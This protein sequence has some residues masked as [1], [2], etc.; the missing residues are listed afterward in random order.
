VTII[1]LGPVLAAVL[2]LLTLFAAAVVR[3]GGLGGARPVVT[4]AVRAAVQLA[5]VSL[6]IAAVL[7]S[8]WWTALFVLLMATVAAVTS[9]RRISGYRTVPWT[10]VSIVAGTAPVIVLLLSTRLVPTVPV[11]VVPI[12]GILIGNAMTVTTLAG[13]RALDELHGRRG[14]Y[15]AALALGLLSRDA[16]LEICRPSAGQ[17]LVPTMDQTRTVGLVT[18]PGAFVGMLLGGAGPVQAGAAQLVVLIGLLAA[19]AIA[20]LIIVE[21]IAA[22]AVRAS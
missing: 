8:W 14:E 9:A 19:Q 5:A 13:R 17:A 16:A 18:L 21:L 12:A 2:G 10:A 6:L 15:E 22:G 3:L 4:A 7:R 20:V 1:P 11:A